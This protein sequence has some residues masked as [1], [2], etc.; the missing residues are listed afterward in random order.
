MAAGGG[1]VMMVLVMPVTMMRMIMVVAMT[2]PVRIG[3]DIVQS[4]L[5]AD[6]RCTNAAPQQESSGEGTAHAVPD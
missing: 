2:V 5:P 4:G 1:M 3:A 6:M